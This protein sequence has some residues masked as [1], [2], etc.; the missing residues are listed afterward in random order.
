MA[1]VTFESSA[2]RVAGF[3]LASLLLTEA[4][5]R[6]TGRLE[7]GMLGALVAAAVGWRVSGPKAAIAALL[8][9]GANLAL[10]VWVVSQMSPMWD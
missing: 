10:V 3:G 7:V 9:G 2:I 4:L 1:R 5:L 8:S 6:L